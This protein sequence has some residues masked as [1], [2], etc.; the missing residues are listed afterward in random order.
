MHHAMEILREKIWLKVKIAIFFKNIYL[1][2]YYKIVSV[3]LVSGILC[4]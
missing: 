4:L 3:T 1:E 2:T